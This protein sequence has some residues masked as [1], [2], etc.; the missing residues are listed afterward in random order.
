[1]VEKPDAA[2]KI[3]RWIVIIIIALMALDF[4]VVVSE[5][6]W[7]SAFLILTIALLI[8][9]VTVFSHRLGVQIPAEFQIL[10]LVFVFAALFLGEVQGYY[11]RIWWWDIALHSTSGLLMGILGFLLVYVLNESSRITFTM[12][13]HFVA[14]F[15]FMFAVAVGSLWEIF[16]FAM[17]S[18]FGTQMQKP[19]L[20]D[21]SGLTDTMW[22]MIVNTIGAMLIS[23]LGWWY[24]KRDRRS[25]IDTWIQK[26]IE[27]NP[28]WFHS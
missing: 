7:L 17:D 28:D 21:P 24:M 11:E 16:E 1:M 22:D 14:F 3:K 27:R 4:V 12:T 13:P 18:I 6:R 20:N 8:L 2:T 9:F 26:F 19:M 5:A 23:L 15:A 10:A 25:F